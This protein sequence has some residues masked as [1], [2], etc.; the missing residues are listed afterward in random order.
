MEGLEISEINFSSIDLKKRRFDS[1]FYKKDN[2]FANELLLSKPNKPFGEII[3]LLTDYH[4]NGS[5]ETLREHVVLLQ[6]PNYAHMIRTTDFIRDDFEKDIISITENAYKYL[7]KTQLFGGE[8]LINKIGTYT[9]QSFLMPEVKRPS[10]LGM[11]I[12]MLRLKKGYSSMF[13][14]VYLTSKI[15]KILTEQKISGASPKS[16]DKESIRDILIPLF[17]DNFQKSI[18][19]LVK[20]SLNTKQA[21]KDTYK[22]AEN[23]L[24]KELKLEN[25]HP[26]KE[27]VNIKNFK[28]S[29]VSSGRLDAEYYQP[30]YEQVVDRIKTTNFDTLSNLVK[31]KKSIEPGSD[32]YSEEG[33]PFIRV[34]DYN[35][36]GFSEPDKKLSFSFYKEN[37]EKLN[38]L[39]PK[40][41]TILFSK[42]G[43]VGTA[44]MLRNDANFVTSG[45]I[46]HLTVRDKTQIIPEYLTLALNS[47][48]VQMQAER[49]AGGSIILHWRVGEI[50]NV[51][52][53]VIDF[54]IQ[55][56]I[57][58]LV[59]E[60]FKLKKQSEQ[61]LELAKTAVEKAIEENEEKATNYINEKLTELKIT[62]DYE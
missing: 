16:I 33:L 44:Y 38:K 55:E 53:P 20:K 62:I 51:V 54:P 35:K 56:K 32:A 47:K 57:A 3:E 8:I 39:K 40:K 28:E 6:E 18:E 23:F 46:L 2:L 29:F 59:E 5:Y 22:K 25:F 49:D 60:S 21:Q 34:S 19:V 27:P 30:K 48:L 31:I 4:A 12:F 52:V 10:S 24:L 41:E 15:G 14:Q 58:E 45:A 1:E 50:E 9:G 36:F 26:S 42:D 37:E 7:T 11:N 43:S 61:L 13:Y 17:S